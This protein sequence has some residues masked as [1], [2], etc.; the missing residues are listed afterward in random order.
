VPLSLAPGGIWA[1]HGR[2]KRLP[3]QFDVGAANA[4]SARRRGAAYRKVPGGLIAQLLNS[5]S[6]VV[7]ISVNRLRELRFD[8][9]KEGFRQRNPLRSN[10]LI[11]G[12]KPQYGFRRSDQDE[13]VE[14]KWFMDALESLI[15]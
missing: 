14:E 9:G 5:M 2:L 4:P 8:F 11:A 7:R 6:G 3:R 12:L 10:R 13:V 1:N 15:A